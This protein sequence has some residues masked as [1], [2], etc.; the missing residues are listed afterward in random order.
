MPERLPAPDGPR[1]RART[2][3]VLLVDDRAEVAAALA[4][5]LSA[6]PELLV[7]GT[8]LGGQLQAAVL[9]QTRP[10]VV[11]LDYPTLQR[12]NLGARV[13]GWREAWPLLRLLV[14]APT[15][16]ETELLASAQFGAVGCLPRTTA[17]ADLA[18][19]I[20]RVRAGEVLLPTATL[21]GALQQHPPRLNSSGPLPVPLAAP[22]RPREIEV[23]QALADGRSPAQI[24]AQLG[25]SPHTVRTHIKSAMQKLG[26]RSTLQ[27]VLQAL[28]AGLI[29]LS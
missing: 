16:G 14:L 19:A 10:D 5:Q 3:R 25:L 27:A 11:V 29:R 15:V 24:A 21:L 20:H 12:G 17:A 9:A 1:S 8:L 18:H 26:T 7:V 4:T 6:C 13:L 2:T 22:L 23:L 28:R